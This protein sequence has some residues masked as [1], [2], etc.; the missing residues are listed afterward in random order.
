H[1]PKIVKTGGFL[2][3]RSH[4]FKIIP[5]SETAKSG[6]PNSCQ[7]GGCH[8]NKSV[9]WALDAFNQH[10]PDFQDSLTTEQKR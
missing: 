5:P 1:M 2:S 4:A 9:D 10:Y 7:N 8:D 6:M 3:L